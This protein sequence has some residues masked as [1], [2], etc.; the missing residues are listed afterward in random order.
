[1]TSVK[2]L[3][4][5]LSE[6]ERARDKAEKKREKANLPLALLI[7]L[8]S[9]IGIPFNLFCGL[10]FLAGVGFTIYAGMYTMSTT[11]EVRRLNEQI[12]QVRKEIVSSQ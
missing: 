8:V 11:G 7:T 2:E 9:L 6:L 12:V 1:M 10:P 5:K 4:F 3:E